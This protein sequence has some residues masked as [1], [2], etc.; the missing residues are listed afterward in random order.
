MTQCKQQFLP[1]LVQSEP[2]YQHFLVQNEAVKEPEND[3]DF[4]EIECP[5]RRYAMTSAYSWT[6]F[7][8]IFFV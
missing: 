7:H 6:K 4:L 2:I 8:V 1:V 5:T 3:E